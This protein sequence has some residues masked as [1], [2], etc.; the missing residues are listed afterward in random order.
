MRTD[1]EKKAAERKVIARAVSEAVKKSGGGE[2]D[3]DELVAVRKLAVELFGEA[4]SYIQTGPGF[5]GVVELDGSGLY[6]VGYFV[7]PPPLGPKQGPQHGRGIMPRRTEIKLI[8]RSHRELVEQS[9][10]L[11]F[12]GA[13]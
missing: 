4:G 10:I 1:K 6:Y 3:V 9:R 5:G 2:I 8:G 7:D 13:L 12:G 11:K